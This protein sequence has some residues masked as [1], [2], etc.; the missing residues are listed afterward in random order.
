[1]VPLHNTGIRV[2]ALALLQ[3]GML[4]E[5]IHRLLV[6]TKSTIFR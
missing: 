1:M 2:Q 4:A 6:P 3:M 5:E